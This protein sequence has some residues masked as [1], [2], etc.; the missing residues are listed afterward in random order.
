MTFK[1]VLLHL[2]GNK[3]T[4]NF[5][6][7]LFQEIP[8][9]LSTL[10]QEINRRE[11]I[12]KSIGALSA[13]SPGLKSVAN[14][15]N[16]TNNDPFADISDDELLETPENL[17]LTKIPIAR[18]TKLVQ[19]HPSH[20]SREMASK[21]WGVVNYGLQH[22]HNGEIFNLLKK[23]WGVDGDTVIKNISSECYHEAYYAGDLDFI[24]QMAIGA[25]KLGIDIPYSKLLD[26]HKQCK[27]DAQRRNEAHTIDRKNAERRNV[28][29]KTEPSDSIDHDL[30][31][32][33][34][35]GGYIPQ[36]SYFESVLDRTI[37]WL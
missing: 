1:V 29:A 6:S 20:G 24:K 15:L 13:L 8:M 17:W 36:N 10:L 18:L 22:N 4:K 28:P 34:N 33:G 12:Q 5:V 19:N 26:A 30:A 35:E 14:M 2:R 37:K 11:F 25:R 31:Q 7:N 16:L 21:F 27:I 32:W 3:N 9:K 23:V